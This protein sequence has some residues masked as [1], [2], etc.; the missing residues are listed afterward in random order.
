M[1]GWAPKFISRPW[2]VERSQPWLHRVFNFY[3]DSC[4]LPVGLILD[5]GKPQLGPL[6]TSPV[7]R[8]GP[9]SE[10]TPCLWIHCKIFDLFIWEGGLPLFP[11]SRSARWKI[12][13]FEHFCQVTMMEAGWILRM[14][15]V[16]SY[17][18][19]CIFHIIRILFAT[20]VTQL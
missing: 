15:S 16:S 3:L 5:K 18:A 14:N 8:A 2:L 20:S 19:C 10:I 11:R 17:F 7:D 13:P 6:F 12:V 9:V 4:V 1:I